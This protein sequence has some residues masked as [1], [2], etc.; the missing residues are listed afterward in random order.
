MEIECLAFECP[1]CK[2]VQEEMVSTSGDFLDFR[3]RKLFLFECEKCGKK[4]DVSI[5]Y[6]KKEN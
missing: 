4:Y 6:E 2:T 5:K 1:N 3:E